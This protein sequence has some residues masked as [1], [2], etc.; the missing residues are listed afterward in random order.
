MIE[1]LN[2]WLSSVS[3]YADMSPDLA[4]RA[5]INLRMKVAGRSALGISDWCRLFTAQE[6][7]A[8][9]SAFSRSAFGVSDTRRVLCFVYQYFSQYSGL[10][11]SRVRPEDQLNHDLHFSLVCWFDWRITFC[12]DFF[13]QFDL[14]LSDC[15]DEDEF[16]T[17]GE[18]VSFLSEQVAGRCERS[19]EAIATH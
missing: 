1:S 18:L 16:N 4:L 2:N 10:D 7:V 12:E 14:D 15:F 8:D 3:T 11:F 5:Q 17:I 6:A 13:E 19:A 9:T